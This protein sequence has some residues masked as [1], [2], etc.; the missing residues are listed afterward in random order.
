[1]D[2]KKEKKGKKQPPVPK[3]PVKNSNPIKHQHRELF[4]SRPRNFGIGQDIRPPHDVTRFVKWPLYIRRQRQKAILLRRLKVP[5]AV[6]QFRMVL[7]RVT[8]KSLFK[9]IRKYRPEGPLQRKLRLK[10]FAQAQ[11]KNPQSLA[12]P[13][14][15]TV[16]CGLQTVTR[17]IETK[18]AKLVVIAND[19]NP[20]ELVV[21]M[22]SLCK[23]LEVPFCIVKDRAALGRLARS[24][25]TTCMA[26]DNIRN[27]DKPIFEKILQATQ[28]KYGDRF[29]EFRLKWGGLVLGK[30]HE[31]KMKKQSAAVAAA[32]GRNVKK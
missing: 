23:K 30:K 8:K 7:D 5:P 14:L 24:K 17:L 21:W 25:K 32:A 26:F 10:K 11:L 20:L 1:V 4:V 29:D 9:L 18:R 28:I 2:A 13:R 27:E 19:V 16:K 6:N 15:P 12:P 31:L 3:E 22:P